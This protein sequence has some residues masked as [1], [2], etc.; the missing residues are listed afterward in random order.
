MGEF[1]DFALSFNA[2][3]FACAELAVAR[4]EDGVG[5]AGVEVAAGG[6][7]VHLQD[8]PDVSEDAD[9]LI[10]TPYKSGTEKR[11]EERDA[12][13]PLQLSSRHVEFVTEPVNVEKGR[14]EFV[15]DE[16]WAVIVYEGPLWQGQ[17]DGR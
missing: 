3:L 12:I 11:C 13:V 14:G 15:E 7:R 1:H 6:D 5:G 2:A 10:C 4:N 16:H 17:R 9:R 8:C